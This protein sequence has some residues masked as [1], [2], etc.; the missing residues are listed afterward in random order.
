MNIAVKGDWGA[1]TQ[2]QR[3]VT[4][5]MCRERKRRNFAVVITTGD[6]FY[7]PDGRATDKN[8]SDPERCLIDGGVTWRAVWG[9]HDLAGSSTKD[10]LG[11]ERRYTWS[12]GDVGFFMLDSNNVDAD[13]TRWLETQLKR[14]TARVKIAA[15]HHPV[16]TDGPHEDTA[17]IKASWVPLFER[18]G[19]A[20]VL[21][22]H[23]HDYEHA[24]SG[25]VTYVVTGGGGAQVYPCLRREAEVLRCLPENHFLL[26]TF[27]ASSVT[28]E[29]IGVDGKRLDRFK[30]PISR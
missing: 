22:G 26:L 3:D 9:N 21:T 12:E 28:V 23:N 15:F 14:S 11:A 29:A 25:G 17:A 19:V 1:G 16:F 30:V 20:L 8:F 2:A 7:R 27:T 6:N 13:Q 5:A 18:W 4:A 24:V 10:V